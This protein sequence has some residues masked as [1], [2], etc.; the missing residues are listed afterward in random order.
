M[1]ERRACDLGVKRARP[2]CAGPGE[3]VEASPAL[4]VSRRSMFVRP[5]AV[6]GS[7]ESGKED[8][9]ECH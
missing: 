6:V 5:L 4:R 7:G 9:N 2:E 1:D 3:C 8:V